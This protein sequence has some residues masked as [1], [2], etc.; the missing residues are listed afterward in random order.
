MPTHTHMSASVSAPVPL[1]SVTIGEKRKKERRES[2]KTLLSWQTHTHTVWNLPALLRKLKW[3]VSPAVWEEKSVCGGRSWSYDFG[4]SRFV[5]QSTEQNVYTTAEGCVD[6][7]VF[8]FMWTSQVRLLN[9]NEI[10]FCWPGLVS[11]VF[12]LI[13]IIEFLSSISVCA[14]LETETVLITNNFIHFDIQHH[15]EIPSE[16]DF[17]LI[18]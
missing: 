14:C 11:C 3:F 5:E 8:M 18:L 1:A 2:V 15:S 12:V 9:L 7:A 10:S 13:S 16:C 6:F 4:A 17:L